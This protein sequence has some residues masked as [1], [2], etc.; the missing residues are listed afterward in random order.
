MFC[1]VPGNIKNNDI[2]D[3]AC[4]SYTKW[5]DDVKLLKDLGVNSYRYSISWSR[6][7]PNGKGCVNQKGL[8]YCKRLTDTLLNEGIAPNITLYHWDLPYELHKQGGWIN[9]NITDWF[10]DYA[11]VVFK[12]I[13]NAALYSTVNEPIAIYV[14]YAKKLFAP[15]FGLEEYGR[16]AN[17]NIL[18]AHGKAVE[19]FR[20]RGNSG[21]IGVVIDVWN[22]VPL[23]HNSVENKELAEKENALAHGSYL[24]QIFQGEYDKRVLAWGLVQG[25]Y[26]TKNLFVDKR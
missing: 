8:D 20:S 12:E 3:T 26:L 13:P 19:R 25:L 24:R 21:K 17:H 7:M 14:G 16:V 11:E 15:S 2:T 5:E 23:D 1:R 6:I 10:G 22:R 9:R 4:E 18:L